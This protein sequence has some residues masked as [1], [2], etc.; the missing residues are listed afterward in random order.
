MSISRFIG[1]P[2]LAG[3]P[4][5]LACDAMGGG[6]ARWLRIFGIDTSYTPG[7][8]DAA[9]V[10]HALTERRLVISSDHKLFER[11]EF[12]RGTL[13]GLL[14]PPGL[15]LDDQVAA[16]VAALRLEIGPPRCSLC[17]GVLE[18][19]S[20]EDVGDRV[21][22]RSLIWMTE[23]YVCP[24]CD[25]VFWKGTHWRRI[26]P[27]QRRLTESRNTRSERNDDCKT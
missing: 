19:A 14:L 9:L 10:A 2:A 26:E 7:I 16:A 22:A 21:P 17:N 25:K 6:L 20:R 24:A 4:P 23:F 15:K 13:A 8:A 3:H 5:R 11:R 27:L 18:I 12:S 1:D